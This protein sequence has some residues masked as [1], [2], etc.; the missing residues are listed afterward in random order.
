MTASPVKAD[1]L[2]VIPVTKVQRDLRISVLLFVCGVVLGV[3]GLAL[4]V[5]GHW[6]VAGPIRSAFGFFG[7][8]L[9]FGTSQVLTFVGGLF[10]VINWRMIRGARRRSPI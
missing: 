1:D 5:T 6:P 9:Y 7:S 3:V 10:A 2:V 8:V 4:Q